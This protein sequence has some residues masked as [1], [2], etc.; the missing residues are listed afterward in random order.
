MRDFDWSRSPLGSPALWPQPLK[1]LVNLMLMATQPMF[2]AWGREQVF[3]YNDPYRDV[4]ADKH[5]AALGRPFLEVWSEIRHDISPLVDRVF[6]GDP[7]HMDDISLIMWRRGWPEETHFAFSYTPVLG[8]SGEIAGLF[9]VCLETTAQVMAERRQAFRLALEEELQ[10]ASDPQ[11]MIMAAV[12]ALGRHLKANRVGYGIVDRDGVTVQPTMGYVD[13]VA[14]LVGAFRL[15]PFGLDGV[16]TQAQGATIVCRD[17]DRDPA[18]APAV[19]AGIET[20][21]F[22]AVP[23]LRERVFSAVLY[24]NSREPREWTPHEVELIE[25]TAGRLWD[26]TQRAH[27]EAALRR[28]EAHLAGIFAQTGAGFAETDLSGRFVAVNDHFCELAGHPREA[29]LGLRVQD[30]THQDDREAS[31]AR[32]E[33]VAAMGTP[34][35]LEKRYVAEDGSAVWVASTVSLIGAGQAGPT[36][37]VVAIDISEQKK[38]EQDLVA[39]KEAAEEANLAKSM[40]IANM[41]HELRTPLSAIIG[42][43]EMLREELADGAEPED[44]EADIGKVESNARHLLGLI[45][46]VLDLSKIESGKME[47]F[48]EAFDAAAMVQDVAATVDSL[49]RKNGNTLALEVEAGLGSMRSDLTKVRQTLLNFL[50]NAAKFTEDGTITLSAGRNAADPRFLL[51]SVRDEGIGMTEGQQAKLFQRFSQADA[52]TTRKFGGTGLGLSITQAFV[53]MLGGSI[54]VESAPGH[55][56]TFTVR[57]PVEF[58]E[59]ARDDMGTAARAGLGEQ[60]GQTGKEMV[61][62]IDD[63]PA[64]LELMAR[65]L[66]RE[67]FAARTAHDGASGLDMAKAL[68]PKVILLDVTMPG[69]DGWSVL[70]ALKADPDLADIPVIMVTFISDN[71][72]ASTLGAADFVSKPVKWERFRQVM[73]RFRDRT[74]DV[75]VVDDDPDARERLRAALERDGWTVAEAVNG[76]DALDQVRQTLPRVILLDLEM[77]VMDG[78]AFLHAFRALPGCQEIPVVVITARDLSRQ[79]RQELLEADK[80]LAKGETSL[81]ALSNELLAATGGTSPPK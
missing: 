79:D 50:S 32:L 64:Q 16:P 29:L 21:A 57:L 49:V 33:R 37:L 15:P 39:A 35:T 41:S 23:L 72:L 66:A 47:V 25:T 53:T 42:Y 60:E 20:R 28:S 51:F 6:S 76:Q 69:M 36:L 62:V 45:N 40:F 81:R 17:V 78:F 8:E 19:W 34:D 58:S 75:L 65:F 22:V 5:P 12:G 13:G 38:A 48:V 77:P 14:P 7:V 10:K 24:V 9:G 1:T 59:A 61:L 26:A 56:S 74:G 70:R 11:A 31:A 73:D 54:S 27:A 52:S 3:L 63:D 55:G 2:I 18:G 30:I 46:D 4:L 44:L 43:S 67:G 80:V 68:R 71:G